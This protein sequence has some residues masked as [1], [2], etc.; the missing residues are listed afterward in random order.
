MGTGNKKNHAIGIQSNKKMHT[1]VSPAIKKN[2]F[3]LYTSETKLL[4]QNTVQKY[5]HQI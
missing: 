1:V 3:C 4:K 5:K 2:M